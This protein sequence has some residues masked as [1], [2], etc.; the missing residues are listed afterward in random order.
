MIDSPR[1][2]HWRGG[3]WYLISLRKDPFKGYIGS[4]IT[5][6]CE[7]LEVVANN[8]ARFGDYPKSRPFGRHYKM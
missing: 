4:T 8:M 6:D 1:K 3:N 7:E 5:L 2:L